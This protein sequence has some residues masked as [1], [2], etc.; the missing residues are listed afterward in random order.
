MAIGKQ[1]DGLNCIH[2]R[3][4]MIAISPDNITL[5]I[6]SK[7]LHPLLRKNRVEQLDARLR[8]LAVLD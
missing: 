5:Q 4:V 7:G 3:A 6:R 1:L 2:R 8:N